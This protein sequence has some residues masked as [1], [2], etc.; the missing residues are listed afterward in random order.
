[1][2]VCGL[3]ELAGPQLN[4]SAPECFGAIVSRLHNL[5]DDP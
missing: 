1:M 2:P 4:F 3:A 5:Q